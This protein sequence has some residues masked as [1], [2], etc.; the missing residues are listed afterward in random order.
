M[1]QVDVP[2]YSLSQA[3]RIAGAIGDQL[4]LKPARPLQVAQALSVQPTTGPFRMLCGASM[5]YGLTEGGYNAAQISLTELGRRIVA[6]TTDGDD[7]LAMREAMLKPRVLRQFLERYDGARLPRPDIARNVLVELGVPRE[8]A[9]KAFNLISEGAKTV[10]F[11]R[12]INGVPFVDLQNA[13]VS[14]TP[15]CDVEPTLNGTACGSGPLTE[16]I[17]VTGCAPLAPSSAPTQPPR[18]F[19]SHGR[20]MQIVEQIKTML[21]I[22]EVEY[23]VAVEEEAP[24]IPVPE[25]VLGAMRRCNG[26][27][28]CVTVDLST[29]PGAPDAPGLVNQ[30]VLIEIG[31]AFV[32]YDKRV[33]LLWDRRIPVPS[34]LQGLYRC[35]FEGNELSWSVGMKLMETIKKFKA[36][37]EDAIANAR[38]VTTA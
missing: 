22:A 31:A 20:N 10:G 33:V 19:I 30:N 15:A 29:V 27:V 14:F 3:L 9:E 24:A 7:A 36:R 18:I 17:A 25:K 2:Y 34:N 4:G 23:E 32:L 28:I 35:E 11:L 6:P 1:S 8:A 16:P 12:E 26:A 21:N 37:S 13:P 38:A 5:A